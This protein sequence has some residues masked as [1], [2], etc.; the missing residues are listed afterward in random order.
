MS[1]YK[2]KEATIG[3]ATLQSIRII[4]EGNLTSNYTEED[5][6]LLDD[7]KLSIG[8]L[9]I[10]KDGRRCWFDTSLD[11]IHYDELRNHTVIDLELWDDPDAMPDCK[12]DLTERDLFLDPEF[13]LWME[14]ESEESPKYSI[15]V[16]LG[17]DDPNLEKEIIMICIDEN[18]QRVKYE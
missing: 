17:D 11:D 4:A 5:R 16:E 9:D 6:V 18:Q 1:K 14:Y 10:E 13:Y 12:Q 2:I 3:N 15:R 7:D 8:G